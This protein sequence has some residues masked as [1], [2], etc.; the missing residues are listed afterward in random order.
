M[1]SVRDVIA[2]KKTA[3]DALCAAGNFNIVHMDAM[4]NIK[5]VY[6]GTNV[7]TL[8]GLQEM[9]GLLLT[10]T[11]GSY[12]AFDFIAIGTS[13]TAAAS[14]ETTLVAEDSRSAGTGTQVKETSTNDTSQ[15]QVTFSITGTDRAIAES[16]VFNSS[17]AGSMLCRK[18]FS[19]INVSTGDSLQVTWKVKFA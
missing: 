14:S 5:G 3:K 17:S 19:D 8:A 4:G 6:D 7:I 18:T 15:L 9:S 10:D 13:G 12:T 1:T 11:T 2:R 16:G